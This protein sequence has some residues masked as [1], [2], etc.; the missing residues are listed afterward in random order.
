MTA[1]QPDI[2]HQAEELAAGLPPLLVAAER[3]AATVSQ[4]VHG[5]RR[6]GQGETFWQFRRYQPGDSTQSIDWRQSA[7]SQPL[8]VRETEWEAAQSVWLW[9]DASPSMR[10]R[11]AGGHP[12]KIHRADLLLLALASLLA[13]GGE[14]VALLGSRHPP[15][16][17]R[18][19]LTRLAA[20]IGETVKDDPD[21]APASLPDYQFLPCHAR[22]VLIGDFLSP[23]PEIGSTIGA[24]TDIGVGGHLVQ[25]LD[26]AEEILPFSGR[27]RFVGP[28]KE[29]EVLVGRVETTR[30]DYRAEMAAHQRGLHALARQARWTL[31]VHRTDRS[32]ETALLPLFLTLSQPF[33]RLSSQTMGR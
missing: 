3:V 2:H 16:A 25:V 32:A 19:A 9:R 26:P 4:G 6:V 31:T 20:L 12:A 14:H 22:L 13:R 27:V 11:S 15:A 33:D 1:R 21:E 28:E 29:G 10:Y 17:G 23:L 30:Q 24:F 7:K 5:R 8:Y 18:A